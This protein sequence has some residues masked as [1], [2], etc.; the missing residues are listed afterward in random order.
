[1]VPQTC[2]DSVSQGK[3]TLYVSNTVT[4][5]FKPDKYLGMQPVV[6]QIKEG[7]TGQKDKCRTALG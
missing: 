7:M 3:H 1:V 5:S 4:Q 6:N 2:K